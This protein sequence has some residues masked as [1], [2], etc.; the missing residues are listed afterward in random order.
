MVG[1]ISD[2]IKPHRT[3][4][5]HDCFSIVYE[6]AKQADTGNVTLRP[7]FHEEKR[8]RKKN[9]DNSV[10]VGFSLQLL[11]LIKASHPPSMAGVTVPL[12]CELLL[13]VKTWPLKSASPSGKPRDRGGVV[14][15]VPGV[16]GGKLATLGGDMSN[17]LGAKV[18]LIPSYDG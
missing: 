7:F 1:A 11:S 4:R 15:R 3:M 16:A 10:Q 8:K 2:P 18:A 6:Q 17:A 12:P 9:K 14:D 5:E 13:R